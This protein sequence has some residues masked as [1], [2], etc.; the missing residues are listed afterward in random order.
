MSVA[1]DV[2]ELS[3]FKSA[4]LRKHMQKNRVLH[5]VPVV[6]GEGILTA[7]VEYAVELVSRDVESHRIRA[8]VEVHRVQVLEI[9]DIGENTSRLRIVFEVVKHSVHLVKFALGIHAFDA[10]LIAVR[11]AY[12]PRFVR[13][14]V[15]NM[16]V[17]VMHVV[18]LFCQ[19]HK[20][21]SIA[22]LKAVRRS[23]II[24]NS[25]ERSYLL[26]MQNFFYSVRGSAV[27]PFGADVKTFV[28]YAFVKNLSASIDKN[29]VSNAH[30]FRAFCA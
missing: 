24:G 23:V 3:D 29:F 19:I 17:E 9:V 28:A 2:Y 20:I 12:G 13:P 6:C 18:A 21:S 8:R 11:L 10:E 22:D 30:I 14:T 1:N 15:P 26:T 7:L 5:D 25:F 27:K 4:Y 16:G